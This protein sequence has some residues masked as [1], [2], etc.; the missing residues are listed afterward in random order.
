MAGKRSWVEWQVGE[1]TSQRLPCCIITTSPLQY[2]FESID[3]FEFN[4]APTGNHALVYGASGISGWAIVNAILNDYPSKDTFSK[5]SA[6]VNRPLT[7]EMALWPDDP[8]LQIISGID[9]LKGSQEE[10]ENTIKEK[11]P[12]VDTVTQVYFYGQFPLRF[13]TLYRRIV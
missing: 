11:V 8:R 9:L 6:L 3:R 1:N 12:D 10:L 4:M 7:R 2:L 5:V 13:F